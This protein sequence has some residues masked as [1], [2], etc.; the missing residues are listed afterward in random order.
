MSADAP[1]GFAACDA[2][3]LATHHAARV[4]LAQPLEHWL[5]HEHARF[6]AGYRVPGRHDGRLRVF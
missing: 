2:E 1:R 5:V 6:A 3:P 4:R